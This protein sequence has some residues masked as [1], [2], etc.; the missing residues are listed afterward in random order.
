M[1]FNIPSM[2]C[3]HCAGAVTKAVR[4]IDP[5]AEVTVDLTTKKVTVQTSGD[6]KAAHPNSHASAF[7]IRPKRCSL[8][9]VMKE[10]RSAILP[11]L[12]VSGSRW[13]DI[14]LAPRK[15]CSILSSVAV[16]GS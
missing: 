15:R 2:S 3:G 16:Q 9:V 12:L 6:R 10:R 8:K 4:A 11:N 14:I 13:S 5:Q 7:W 1:E